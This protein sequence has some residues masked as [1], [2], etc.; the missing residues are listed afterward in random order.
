LLSAEGILSEDI[1]VDDKVKVLDDCLF[2][3][4]LQRQ[5]SAARELEDF[6]RDSA[7]KKEGDQDEANTAKYFSAL[8]VRCNA[9][10]L[11]LHSTPN[12]TFHTHSG[13]L[14]TRTN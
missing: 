2:C 4:H 7:T 5:Y 13:V 8:K 10:I 11:P 12:V 1:T 9:S 14:T 3:I 6:L